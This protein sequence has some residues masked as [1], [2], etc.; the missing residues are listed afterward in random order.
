MTT[1][2]QVIVTVKNK[3]SNADTTSLKPGD[4]SA[5]YSTKQVKGKPTND[6]TMKTSSMPGA[7]VMKNLDHIRAAT[8]Q[9][10][11]TVRMTPT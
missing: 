5:H 7:R 1:N 10:A 6:T 8:R 4:I 3:G 2:A 9:E 11:T